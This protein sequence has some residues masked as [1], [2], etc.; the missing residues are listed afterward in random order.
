MKVLALVLCV[1]LLTSCSNLS[2]QQL[3]DVAEFNSMTEDVLNAY[4]VNSRVA[5]DMLD[6]VIDFAIWSKWSDQ[7]MSVST[8]D[9]FMDL[10][11]NDD[12]YY[13]YY[14]DNGTDPYFVF[15]DP[16]RTTD[17]YFTSVASVVTMQ[18]IEILG[19]KGAK[20]YL[21]V[22]WEDGKINEIER[23]YTRQDA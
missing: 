7:L 3:Q 4:D 21:K 5:K 11:R 20:L 17:Y 10:I 6:D 8:K 23:Y 18:F 16:I 19:L 1:L 14:L 2:R 13:M 15:F 9:Y 12:P 22:Y